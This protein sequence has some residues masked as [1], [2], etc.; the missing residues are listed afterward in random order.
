MKVPT[1]TSL[2]HIYPEDALQTQQK[3]LD[4][5]L[6]SF[7]SI[8][9][10]P[11]N[12]VSRSP[13]RVNIIGEHIDYSLYEVL[14]MAVTQ[15]ILIAVAENPESRNLRVA[16]VYSE[17]FSSREFEVP[18]EGE[19]EIDAS[20]LEW[21]NY[22]KAGFRGASKLLQRKR[23][24]FV[25]VG[26]DILVH[27]NVPSG[28]GMS[29]SAAFVCASTLAVLRA[30]GEDAINK[31]ELV[32]L[33]IVS[34]RSVGVN[35]GGMDQSASVFPL[36][37]SAI[38]VSFKPELSVKSVQF[39]ETKPELTFV[40]A[41]SFVAADK[42]TT[43]P[44]CYNLRVVEC[45]LAAVVLAKISGL[46]R[47]LPKDSSPL[48]VS[49]RGFQDIYFEEKD[50]IADN[51]TV[52]VD[53]FQVQL[54][55]LVQ[56]TQDYLPQEEGY[57]REQI[58]DIT[59]ISIDDLKSRFESTF[60]VHADRFKLR[61]RALHVFTEALRV[62]EFYSL[63]TSSS[64]SE[65]LLEHLG[66]LMNETQNSCRD[67]Y[68]CSCPELDELCTLARRA[69]S[70]GSRLTGAGWGGCSVHLVPKDKVDAVKNAWIT[71][72]YRKKWPDISDERLEEAIVV[73]KPGS[74][75]S[76]IKVEGGV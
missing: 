76:I 46:K 12:F 48:E 29:S 13:G 2:G 74:G 50:G 49:L 52:S 26:M 4:D 68:D 61:Q 38:Y 6:A 15:D 66:E 17:K 57:T 16:N 41:Q 42:H 3:R 67:V 32:E 72:Y 11:A 73:S 40:V 44:V 34:E 51:T 71:K 64:P 14:P 28:G 45:T 7:K 56:Y 58:S 59:G 43:A 47:A 33:A 10:R 5:L 63:L 1:A 39:P 69:G 24:S 70:Y 18:T 53:E 55:K 23:N 9:G 20:S 30:N 22:F 25:S 65:N 27:G 54:E 21:T 60:K 62:N 37:G 36:R 75:S 31:K 8:Y 19:I 35:S